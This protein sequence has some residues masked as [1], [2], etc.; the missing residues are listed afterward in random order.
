MFDI[1]KLNYV[2]IA[3]QLTP[4]PWMFPRFIAFFYAFVHPLTW[5]SNSFFT[6]RNGLVTDIY[7]NSTSYVVGSLIRYNNSIFECILD[8]TGIVPTNTNNWVLYSK[9]WIGT[10]DRSKFRPNKQ[11]FEWMLNKQFSTTFT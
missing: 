11:T 5:V 10:I 6:Y 1:F 2:S 7:D 4:T 3:L 9:N 8:C